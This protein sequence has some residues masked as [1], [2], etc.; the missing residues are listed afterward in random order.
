MG[1]YVHILI[2]LHQLR[3]IDL[4]SACVVVVN[5]RPTPNE[6]KDLESKDNNDADETNLDDPTETPRT[7]ESNSRISKT[8]RQTV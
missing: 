4:K 8:S 2:L 3:V 7:R 1:E 6:K 5:S